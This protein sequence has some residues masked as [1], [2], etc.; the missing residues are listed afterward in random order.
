MWS[1]D[2]EG[3]G[4]VVSFQERDGDNSKS[5]CLILDTIHRD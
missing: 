1:E 4:G 5:Y 2:D 3:L